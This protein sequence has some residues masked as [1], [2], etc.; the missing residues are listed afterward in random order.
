MKSNLLFTAYLSIIVLFFLSSDVFANNDR[1]NDSTTLVNYYYHTGNILSWDF[2][3]PMDNWEGITLNPEG[4]VTGINISNNNITHLYGLENLDALTHLNA[5]FNKLNKLT[6]QLFQLTNLIELDL[7]N[8]SIISDRFEDFVSF[9]SL[10][11]LYLNNNNFYGEMPEIFSTLGNL[12]SLKLNDN[13]LSG[14]YKGSV[15]NLCQIDDIAISEGNNFDA[16]WTDFCQTND[17]KCNYINKPC[18]QSDSL[19]LMAFY[20]TIESGLTWDVRQSIDT[21]EGV[22]LNSNGCVTKLELTDQS[23]KGEIASEIGNLSQLQKLAINDSY[24]LSGKIP[25]EIGN[26]SNLNYLS[27]NG[28]NLIGTIPY[29]LCQ[30]SNLVYLDLADNELNSRIPYKLGELT[31]LTYLNLCENILQGNIP[32][33]FSNLINLVYLNVEDNLLRGCFFKELKNLCELTSGIYLEDDDDDDNSFDASWYG[34]CNS[35]QGICNPYSPCRETDSL[36]LLKLHANI[37]NL[38][39]NLNDPIDT[40][41]GVTLNGNGCVVSIYIYNPANSNGQLFSEIDD[42]QH[43][44]DLIISGANL[45]GTLPPE[46]FNISTLKNIN[47]SNNNLEGCFP[48]ELFKRC[49]PILSNSNFDNN[50]FEDTWENF[51]LYTNGS[52]CTEEALD[53]IYWSGNRALQE[54]LYQARNTIEA[55]KS[56]QVVLPENKITTFKAGEHILLQ[57]NFTVPNDVDFIMTIDSCR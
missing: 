8:N 32:L 46:L 33:S 5:S 7:S 6:D 49:D 56:Y 42:F 40:W 37:S 35:N 16:D 19:S 28:N 52:C 12:N 23:L 55:S 10:Q 45:S 53:D 13:L 44:E 41:Q 9:P 26:L 39:W 29:Q 30:L 11:K 47:L 20:H 2:S 50:N 36:A 54:N 25:F 17:G 38:S 3:Q 27:L 4:R 43:L 31:N 1:Q 18:R 15:F 21:W 51:C 57:D 48:Y 22:T 24:Y 14:C 34:F